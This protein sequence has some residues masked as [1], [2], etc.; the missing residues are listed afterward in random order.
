MSPKPI[1]LSPSKP[2]DTAVNTAPA[3]IQAAETAQFANE[4]N[5]RIKLLSENAKV[6]TYGSA[7]A[8][9]FDLYAADT[10]AIAPGRAGT[11]K[12]DVAF[13][14]PEGF[15][16][17]VYSRSG[18]GFDHGARLVN[19]V[20]IVDS[21]Y[22]GEVVARL[23]NDSKEVFVVSLGDRVAQAVIE[24]AMRTVFEV[25]DELSSTERGAGGMGSTGK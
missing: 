4:V 20:G 12:T 3:P 6:P 14:V 24:P 8:A 9:C 2:A 21:D 11:V 17:K 22:R 25:V 5:C 16:L 7:G 15:V 13:E 23:H 10:V 19:S 1:K 18:H